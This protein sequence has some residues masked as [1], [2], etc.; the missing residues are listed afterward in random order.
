MTSQ[1]TFFH[2]IHNRI[3]ACI[4]RFLNNESGFS[5]VEAALVLAIV[6]TVAGLTLPLLVN[7]LENRRQTITKERLTT[8]IDTIGLYCAKT[9]RLPCPATNPKS[10]VFG[11]CGTQSL[12]A[13]SGYLPFR[14]LGLQESQCLDGFGNPIHYS[15]D[16]N[17]TV[18][19]YNFKSPAKSTLT[20]RDQD[21]SPVKTDSTPDQIAIVL[22]SEGTGFKNQPGRHETINLSEEPTFVDAPYSI[23]K[24][25]EHRHILIWRTFEH[26]Y[27]I[28]GKGLRDNPLVFDMHDDSTE[29]T[30]SMNNQNSQ[31]QGRTP[32]LRTPS[33]SGS[34]PQMPSVSDDPLSTDS[35]F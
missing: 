34:S 17:S 18:R 21:G 7:Q 2:R 10:G 28:H 20:V 13:H 19:P 9:K 15:V 12:H 24:D 6:G 31:S 8:L 16:L 30:S 32:N 27:F 33:N 35:V 1:N 22:W 25:Q 4:C 14:E 3:R 11:N 26:L 29:H 5:L 23:A